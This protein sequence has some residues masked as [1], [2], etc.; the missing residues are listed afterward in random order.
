MTHALLLASRARLPLHARRT[1][2]LSDEWTRLYA[3]GLDA[4]GRYWMDAFSLRCVLTPLPPLTC[5]P[6]A[7]VISVAGTALQP[8]G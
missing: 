8:S 7:V 2:I 5:E 4:I 6:N 1:A 3:I